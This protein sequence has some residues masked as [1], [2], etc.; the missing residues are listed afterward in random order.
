MLAVLPQ[1][2]A[3]AELRRAAHRLRR[4]RIA[5]GR[6]SDPRQLGRAG[7]TQRPGHNRL[8]TAH[9]TAARAE[10]TAAQKRQQRRVAREG[11]TQRGGTAQ[12]TLRSAARTC[13]AQ[14]HGA[15]ADRDR[16][17]EDLGEDIRGRTLLWARCYAPCTC[18]FPLREGSR[19]GSVL[20]ARS[21]GRS[22]HQQAT[23]K[24]MVA[25]AA[26]AGMGVRTCT[27][28]TDES[29]HRA[30]EEV[31]GAVRLGLLTPSIGT[32]PRRFHAR[33]APPFGW[34][35]H[36]ISCCR[37]QTYHRLPDSLTKC[38]PSG[39]RSNGEPRALSF[40]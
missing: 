1:E 21:P 37:P 20:A 13:T 30:S 22:G 35:V 6:Y 16:L 39:H 11:P 29:F 2:P 7:P 25:A 19:A 28:L 10:T 40:S 38:P 8:R 27:A 33:T 4:S 32:L 36:T 24:E 3:L 12:R 34:P 9:R 18:E 17:C 26:V 14:P 31:L 23:A 5:Q 15:A